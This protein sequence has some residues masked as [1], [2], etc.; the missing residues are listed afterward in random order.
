MLTFINAGGI[1]AYCSDLIVADENEI[2]FLSVAGYQTAVKGIIAN[3]L[4]Y[5]SVTVKISGEYLYPFR[6]TE[7]YSVHYQK[8]PSGLFQGVILPKIALPNNDES[9]DTFLIIAEDGSLAKELFFKHLDG[10]TEV[11][12]HLAWSDWLWKS[13]L[14]KAWLTPL[15]CLIGDYEGYL[16]EINEDELRDTITMAIAHKSA[17]VMACFEKGGEYGRDE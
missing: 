12:L 14:E 13:F 4:E 5:N 16:V 3:V 10:K 17:E 11:P 2:Y 6:S 1:K 7:K 8:L 15:E 9:K